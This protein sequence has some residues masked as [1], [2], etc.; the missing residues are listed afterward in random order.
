MKVLVIG[1]QGQLGQCLI[2]RLD[3]YEVV[4]ASRSEL[5]LSK[6]TNIVPYIKDISPQ[7]VINLSAYTAVDKAES[8]V[9]LAHTINEHAVA[10][11]AQACRDIDCPLLHVSTDFVFGGDKSEPYAVDAACQPIGA[12]GKSKW[13]GEQAIA[14]YKPQGSIIIRTAWLYSDVGANFMLSMLRLMNQRDKLGIVSDQIGTPTS[15]HSLAR[16]IV[17]FLQQGGNGIYHWT[18][19]GVAS[20]YDFAVAIYEEGLVRGLVPPGV[21]IAP[22]TTAEYPTPASRPAFSVLDKSRTYDAVQAPK[23]HWREELRQVLDR[24]ADNS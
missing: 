9:E 1:A 13:A 16:I 24:L 12:Y 3:G 6:V 10:S 21:S 7:Y 19:A 17:R 20:W 23:I 8:E 4:A 14:R 22:I 15:A 11:I 2:P 18:D 5:D